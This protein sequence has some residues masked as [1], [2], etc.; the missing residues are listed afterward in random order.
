MHILNDFFQILASK[1]VRL[2]KIWLASWILRFMAMLCKPEQM[3]AIIRTSVRTF[4]LV[5]QTKNFHAFVPM[6]WR[7]HRLANVCVQAHCNHKEIKL[8][9]K[10]RIHVHPDSL[11]VRTNYAFQIFIDVM[12]MMV[13]S[14]L[15][16]WCWSKWKVCLFLIKFPF[17][18][19]RLWRSFWWIRMPVIK[20]SM[21]TAHVPV[22][23]W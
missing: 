9:H 18:N 19:F 20:T 5:H 2:L 17:H 14:S 10:C 15:S 21:L 4:A 12:A 11:P 8:A 13:S 1:Y 22:Q 3:L 16:S 7:C 6:E 23:I